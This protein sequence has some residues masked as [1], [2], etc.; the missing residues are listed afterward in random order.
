MNC[1]ELA[2]KAIEAVEEGDLKIIP[3]TYEKVWFDWLNNIQD[4]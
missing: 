3:K 2:K 1:K 4:W